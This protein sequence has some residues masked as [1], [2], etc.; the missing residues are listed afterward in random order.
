MSTVE[1]KLKG[2][3]HDTPP[4]EQALHSQISMSNPESECIRFNNAK[5]DEKET[6]RDTDAYQTRKARRSKTGILSSSMI[7]KSKIQPALGREKRISIGEEV[8]RGLAMEE[9]GSAGVEE[10]M[11]CG[12]RKRELAISSTF[13]LPI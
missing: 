2:K 3:N 1:L 7:Q 12:L 13:P 6:D 5:P 8:E 10:E 9:W 4:I 11:E